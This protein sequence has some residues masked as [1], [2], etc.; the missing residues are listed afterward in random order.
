MTIGTYVVHWSG[1]VCRI[2]NRA[3]LDFTGNSREY[4]VLVPVR[5]QGEKIYVPVEKSSSILRPVLAQNEAEALI[6]QMKEI[7]P[8]SIKDEK[9]RTQ[10]YKD[11][12]YSQ[13]YVNLIKIAK[14][15]YQRREQRSREGKKLAAK[16]A[17]M[18]SLVEK[19]FEEELSIS[20]GVEAEELRELMKK[21]Q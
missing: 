8:L 3:V 9:Q 7:E 19:T 2:E 12:F 14:E 16:D 1:K 13:N 15:L 6:R 11:A 21:Y 5:D 17:Q 18:M 4:L 10:E 20:L